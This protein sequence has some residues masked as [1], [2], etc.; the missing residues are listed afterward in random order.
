M[1]ITILFAA[2]TSLFAQNPPIWS[3]N[4]SHVV[5]LLRALPLVGSPITE[6]HSVRPEQKLQNDTEYCKYED[7]FPSAQTHPQEDRLL[8]SLDPEWSRYPSTRRAGP[9]APPQAASRW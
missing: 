8:L 3:K 4:S 1:R 9:L 7:H 5:T 6:S 2:S